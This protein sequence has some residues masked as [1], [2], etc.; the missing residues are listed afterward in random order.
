[1]TPGCVIVDIFCNAVLWVWYGDAK[2]NMAGLCI[3]IT[4]VRI[5]KYIY[6]YIELSCKHTMF[7]S[8]GS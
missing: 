6:I 5:N 4:Q 7:E 2:V 8:S 3:S 1:M